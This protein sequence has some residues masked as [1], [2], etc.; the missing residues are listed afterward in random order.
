[1]NLEHEFQLAR[2]KAEVEACNDIETLRKLTLQAVEALD[3]QRAW[4]QDRLKAGWLGK[5]P[6]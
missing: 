6:A 3:L 5:D 2:I 1:M 4:L